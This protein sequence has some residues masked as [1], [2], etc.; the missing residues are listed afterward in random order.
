[1]IG[2]HRERTRRYLKMDARSWLARAP[3]EDSTRDAKVALTDRA[4]NKTSRGGHSIGNK[5][6]CVDEVVSLDTARA[7]SE[8]DSGRRL[9]EC[10]PD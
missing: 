3:D 9:E 4:T 5:V 7:S 6:S 8:L 2:T 1:M 10:E